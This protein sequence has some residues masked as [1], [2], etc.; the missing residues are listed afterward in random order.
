MLMLLLAVLVLLFIAGGVCL[1]FGY[2]WPTCPTTAAVF[3][4]GGFGQ[5]VLES[6]GL[7]EAVS[8]LVVGVC[9][10]SCSGDHPSASIDYCRNI[11]NAEVAA[12]SECPT[13]VDVA[14]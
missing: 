10:P 9:N 5:S 7:C 14:I 13:G 8:R 3:V 12:I 2:C 4:V 6:S 11:T 1:A